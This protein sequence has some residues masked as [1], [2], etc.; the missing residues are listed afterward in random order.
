MYARGIADLRAM[1]NLIDDGGFMFGPNPASIDAC[2]YGFLANIYFYD[3]D[4]PL[5]QF[6]L[7]QPKLVGHVR[8]MRAALNADALSR[9]TFEN[10]CAVGIRYILSY[11]TREHVRPS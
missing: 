9:R 3:I 6:V 10:S 5:K 2:L 7:S 4:T 8:V 1:A 11:I